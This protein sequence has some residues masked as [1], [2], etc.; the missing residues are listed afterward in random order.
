MTVDLQV[1]RTLPN[2]DAPRNKLATQDAVQKPHYNFRYQ[3]GSG[4]TS[5]SAIFRMSSMRTPS[6]SETN[7]ISYTSRP[8]ICWKGG[9]ASLMDLRV[10][11][12]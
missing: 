8:T 3:S 7:A 5:K 6:G 11:R 10:I 2:R 4:S 1:D 12:V 9:S